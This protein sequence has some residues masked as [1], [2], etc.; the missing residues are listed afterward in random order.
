MTAPASFDGS[1][2]ESG[3]L[4]TPVGAQDERINPETGL[5]R[6]AYSDKNPLMAA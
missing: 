6:G 1:P 3:R 4:T 2:D 5:S